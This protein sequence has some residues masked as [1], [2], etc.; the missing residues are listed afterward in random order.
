MSLLFLCAAV[1]L[2]LS[3]SL[4]IS[5]CLS[6]FLSIILSLI[7]ILSLNI[8]NSSKWI[9]FSLYFPKCSLI[10]IESIWYMNT[11]LAN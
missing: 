7:L 9:T 10:F 5:R 4:S 3:P 1:C 11:N 6:T 2:Y 8:Y